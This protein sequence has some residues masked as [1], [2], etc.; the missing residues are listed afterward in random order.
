MDPSSVQVWGS[1][2]CKQEQ[3][4]DGFVEELPLQRQTGHEGEE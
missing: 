3:L 4:G 2:N 1:S